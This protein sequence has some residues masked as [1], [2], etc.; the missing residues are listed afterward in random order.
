MKKT[1]KTGKK[2]YFDE[3][4]IKGLEHHGIPIDFANRKRIAKLNGI[5]N[6]DGRSTQHDT[7]REIAKTFGLRIE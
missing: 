5:K 7:L 6:Y 1:V 2:I 4:F 3:P